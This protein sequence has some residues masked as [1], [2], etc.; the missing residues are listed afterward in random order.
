MTMN[1]VQEKTNT[2]Q[3]KIGIAAD[4]GGFELKEILKKMMS[5]ADG[6]RTG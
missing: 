3:V 1:K 4:H 6:Q 5:A 2:A